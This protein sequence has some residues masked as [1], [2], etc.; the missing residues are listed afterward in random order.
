M[1]FT[2]RI[3][4]VLI[5]APFYIGQV[6]QFLLLHRKEPGEPIFA[7]D[8]ICLLTI[9]LCSPKEGKTK[10]IFVLGTVMVG[11]KVL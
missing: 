9:L 5:T 7:H 1:A 10:K 11:I 2:R 3:K 6:V 4:I 8:I